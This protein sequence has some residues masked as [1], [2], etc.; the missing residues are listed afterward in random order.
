MK[1]KFETTNNDFCV[2]LD[3]RVVQRDGYAFF[4]DKERFYKVLVPFLIYDQNIDFSFKSE[5]ESKVESFLH[6]KESHKESQEYIFYL[7]AFYTFV[8]PSFPK[9]VRVSYETDK[10]I[11]ESYYYKRKPSN[12]VLNLLISADNFEIENNTEHLI[13]PNM[14]NEEDLLVYL[15]QYPSVNLILKEID[16]HLSKESLE[17]L[18][19]IYKERLII[20]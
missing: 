7:D 2:Y 9:E 1:V 10:Q 14:G 11:L 20:V 4:S 3:E 16:A 12:S 8:V 18:L 6:S 17:F 5:L 19:D 13:I 15:S